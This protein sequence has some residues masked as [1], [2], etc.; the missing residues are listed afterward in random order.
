MLLQLGAMLLMNI[1]L[2]FLFS[3]LF[4]S[5][6]IYFIILFSMFHFISLHFYYFSQ[7]FCH[8]SAPDLG[9]LLMNIQLLFFSSS[10]EPNQFHFTQTEQEMSNQPDP[11]YSCLLLTSRFASSPYVNEDTIIQAKGI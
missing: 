1:Q 7:P 3:D 8:F 9:S 5:S 10:G 6:L 2:F 4:F 11:T